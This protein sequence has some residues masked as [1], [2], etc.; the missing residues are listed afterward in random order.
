MRPAVF[1]DRDNTIIHND[2]DLGDPKRVVLMKGVAP[3]IAS[4]RGL[5]FRVVV[6]TNQGGVARGLYTEEDVHAVHDRIAQLIERQANGAAIDAF[7]YCPF[8]P[9]GVVEEYKR[10][11]PSRKPAPGMLLQAAQDLNLDLRA[12]WM[13][14]DQMRDVEAGRAAGTRTILLLDPVKAPPMAGEPEGP[15]YDAGDLVEAV[16][17]IAQL[18]T[19]EPLTS[20]Q[21][22][23]KPG[24]PSRRKWDAQR[25]AEIQKPRESPAAPGRDAAQPPASQNP[26]GTNGAGKP[27]PPGPAAFRPWTIGEGRGS[28]PMVTSPFRKRFFRDEDEDEVG[29]G[30]EAG[31][32]VPA[33]QPDVPARPEVSQSPAPRETPKP[34]TPEA[35]PQPEAHDTPPVAQDVDPPA[36]APQDE[37]AA[38]ERPKRAR[39]KRE[40]TDADSPAAV[41][42]KVLRMILQEL[43]SQRGT[44]DEFSYLTIIAVVLQLVALICLLGA[45]W[46]GGA[47]VAMFLR[48]LGV[49]LM[50]QL[51][52]IATLMFGK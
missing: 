43:R 14:G 50:A 38:P 20:P 39:R 41:P 24:E 13:V 30:I 34:I 46:M 51:G 3:A 33:Q 19:P 44:T 40:D 37:P 11:H 27:S 10:E 36:A 7:Y 18:R 15:D 35:P 8:H 49:G 12:S 4:L 17:I 9:N 45:L 22:H 28:K 29:Q 25:I 42:D 32:P 31:P 47:D 23:R 6:V 5:G 48:W 52:V 26:Q 21:P 16:R 2:G 1:L